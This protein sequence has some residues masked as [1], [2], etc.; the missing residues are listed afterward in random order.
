[1][2]TT[3]LAASDDINLLAKKGMLHQLA[4][5]R[6]LGWVENYLE[7]LKAYMEDKNNDT[8]NYGC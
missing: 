3:A 7:V 6:K 8:D 2:D 4:D 5:E 1:M